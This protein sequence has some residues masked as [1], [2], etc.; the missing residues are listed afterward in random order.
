M[1]TEIQ[2][3][4]MHT[5]ERVENQVQE[6]LDKLG[7]KY[8]FIIYGHVFFRKEPHPEQKD[9]V[10]EIRLSTPGPLIF[11]HDNEENFEKAI[12]LV[13]KRLEVQLE[14]RKAEMHPY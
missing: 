12:P 5:I 8:D 4:D 6:K 10:C 9:H 7:K 1:N 14:K 13:I 2:F 3:V 11:A